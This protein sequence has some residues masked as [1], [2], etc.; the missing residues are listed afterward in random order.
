[1][2]IIIVNPT[3]SANQENGLSGGKKEN[4]PR[5]DR[6]RRGERSHNGGTGPPAIA[7][8]DHRQQDQQRS[9]HPQCWGEKT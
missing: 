4:F 7:V 2:R 3:K 1:M 8:P 6:G 5:S 9:G